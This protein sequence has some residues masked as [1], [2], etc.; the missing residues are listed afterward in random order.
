MGFMGPPAQS[1][2]RMLEADVLCPLGGVLLQQSFELQ[3]LRAIS[4]HAIWEPACQRCETDR[5]LH[6]Y[7]K[8]YYTPN[9]KPVEAPKT[10]NPT[11]QALW[12]GP[13]PKL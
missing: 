12:L 6:K 4:D 7:P 8:P 9:P 13:G 5:P 10:L 11:N 1:R 3:G 2:L